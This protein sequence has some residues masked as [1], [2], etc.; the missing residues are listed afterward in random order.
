MRCLGA[1][2]PSTKDTSSMEHVLTAAYYYHIH[3]TEVNLLLFGKTP[4]LYYQKAT[5][6]KSTEVTARRNTSNLQDS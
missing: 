3:R 5:S 4:R 1:Q 6:K 2:L